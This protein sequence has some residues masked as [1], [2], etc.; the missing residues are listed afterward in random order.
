MIA[1]IKK[2]FLH[3]EVDGKDRG[4]LR[5]LWVD[6]NEKEETVVVVYRFSRVVFGVSSS[7][8]L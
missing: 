4:C 2:A 8:S 1:D 6:D 3:L 7:P 5:F